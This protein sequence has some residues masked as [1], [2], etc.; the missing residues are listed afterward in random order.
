MSPH[1]LVDTRS[2][3]DPPIRLP[4]GSTLSVQVNGRFG[5][6]NDAAAA[7]LNVTVVQAS[8]KG[9][10][11]VF[12]CGA[13]KPNTSTQNYTAGQTIPNAVLSKVGTDGRVCIYTTASTY[14]VVDVSGWFPAD[15]D[16][17]SLTPER[18]LDT[19]SG[20]GNAPAGIVGAG[21]TVELQVTGAGTS[22][23]PA[24]A[25]AVVL[26]VTVDGPQ[27]TGHITVY[28]CGSDRPDTSTLNYTKGNAMANASIAKIGAG[29]KVC[30]YTLQPT[31]L[32]A[33]VTGWFPAT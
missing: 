18:L 25:G 24:D 16:F 22:N 20:L 9:D 12:P 23:I 13:A 10:I 30:L 28:P 5:I 2:T 14:L 32:I 11:K 29:G 33:D 27:Q 17:H 15:T 19:R 8:A 7:A 4:A 1:R 26:N 3:V 6:P 31:H 21:K